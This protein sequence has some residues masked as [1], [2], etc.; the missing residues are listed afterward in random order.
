LKASFRNTGFADPLAGIDTTKIKVEQEEK[1]SYQRFNLETLI[2][3]RPA[4][5]P[6]CLIGSRW[7]GRGSTFVLSG[8]P[9]HGKSSLVLYFLSRWAL[10]LP[11]FGIEPDQPLKCVIV[12]AENDLGDMAEPL[13]GQVDYRGLDATER[14]LLNRNLIILQDYE[15]SGVKFATTLENII[16]DFKPYVVVA[17]PLMTYAGC[18]LSRQDQVAEFLYNTLNPI[19]KRS[20]IIF[21]FVHHDRKPPAENGKTKNSRAMH[22]SFGSVVIPAWAREMISLVC[23]DEKNKQFELHFGKRASHTGVGGVIRI[24]HTKE[25]G[26]IRWEQM[27]VLEGTATGPSK[28][29]KHAKM[30]AGL[31]ALLEK[32]GYLGKSTVQNEA[33]RNNWSKV[34]A[35]NFVHSLADGRNYHAIEVFGHPHVS[36]NPNLGKIDPDADKKKVLAF[37]KQNKIVSKNK[38]D[39][40]AESDLPRRL[41]IRL[42][43]LQP[44]WP[45]REK[46]SSRTSF[47]FP[48]ITQRARSTPLETHI[49]T[50][51]STM[52][53]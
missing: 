26:I 32:A 11:A 37:I 8:E 43:S 5:D 42:L 41:E 44:C 6:D 15:S 3:F 12:Q 39:Q 7:L 17:D 49:P 16:E 23:T 18:D 45:K 19:I 50:G 21:G 1:R 46:L 9:G 22:N 47:G 40:W 53:L 35:W 52:S 10:G 48:T 24:R 4:D 28:A 33:R 27:G 20:G 14:E 13:R 25:E 38:L 31:R 29:E 51:G 36:A 34:D 30:E 2:N